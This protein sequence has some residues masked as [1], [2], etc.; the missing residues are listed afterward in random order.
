MPPL[1]RG[2]FYVLV[3]V[4]DKAGAKCARRGGR[5]AVSS[6]GGAFG[7]SWQ[8]SCKLLRHFYHR[9]KTVD[10]APCKA[11][12]LLLPNAYH[13]EYRAGQR[14]QPAGIIIGR[15]CTLP[16]NGRRLLQS[17]R[18]SRVRSWNRTGPSE[19]ACNSLRSRHGRQVNRQSRDHEPNVFMM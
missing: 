18:S 11:N 13:D 2:S 19:Q 16:R 3:E 7:M 9:D 15:G 6:D 14:V 1:W 10:S 12:A 4:N 5:T 17:L 8:S